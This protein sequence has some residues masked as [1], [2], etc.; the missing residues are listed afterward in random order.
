MSGG[1]GTPERGRDAAE[2]LERRYR[3]LLAW[4]PADYRAANE[5][6]MLGVA[7]ARARQGQHWP[8]FGETANL[9][10]SGTRR[11]LGAGLRNPVRRDTA[12]AVAIIGP[13]LLAGASVW[14]LTFALQTTFVLI[15]TPNRVTAA[16]IAMG[17][18]WLLVALA[19]ML[20]RRRL[21]AAGA[22]AGLAALLALADVGVAWGGLVLYVKILAGLLT[23]VAALGAVRAAARPF[24]WRAAVA[25]MACAAM[26]PGWPA[27]E[28]ALTTVQGPPGGP[29]TISSPLSGASL[30]WC[31]A[32]LA[33]LVAVL[34]AA[35]G[36][37]RP[38]VGRRV[39]ALM[40]PLVA[41]TAVICWWDGGLYPDVSLGMLM[42]TAWSWIDPVVTVAAGVG[43][44]LAGVV[45]CKQARRRHR[46]GGAVADA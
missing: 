11:R 17:G 23:A 21:A 2:V 4:Y 39:G 7:L 34:T 5:D 28:G 32:A 46:H 22:W 25:V 12:A 1:E 18:W 15:R 24:S 43:I 45:V 6:E 35:A 37:L 36:W 9:I 3:K 29:W 26:V 14:P 30:W 27:V 42:T 38:A 44:G 10:L 19:G 16:A 31:D 20:N 8:E 41:L 33:G 13:L 40:V